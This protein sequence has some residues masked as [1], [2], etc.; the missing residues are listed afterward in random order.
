MTI[1]VCSFRRNPLKISRPICSRPGLCLAGIHSGAKSQK[2]SADASIRVRSIHHAP[3][4]E[5][6]PAR[7]ASVTARTSQITAPQQAFLTGPMEAGRIGHVRET[8]FAANALLRRPDSSPPKNGRALDGGPSQRFTITLQKGQELTLGCHTALRTRSFA[9]GGEKNCL[10]IVTDNRQKTEL[11]LRRIYSG[12]KARS[13]VFPSI[14]PI[15]IEDAQLVA[16][17]V[18]RASFCHLRA[19]GTG[20]PSILSHSNGGNITV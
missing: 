7:A 3:R 10:E 17:R 11:L 20:I 15:S 1:R 5:I 19:R 2:T 18:S 14:A 4:T 16:S 6:S 9:V 12:A 8:R 13:G